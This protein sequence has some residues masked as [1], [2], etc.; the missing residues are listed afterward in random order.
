[1]VF[2]FCLTMSMVCVIGIR[3]SFFSSF[4]FFEIP[5]HRIFDAWCR[6]MFFSKMQLI[7]TRWRIC[8]FWVMYTYVY[9]N[10]L[11][12]LCSFRLSIASNYFKRKYMF[13]I[14]QIF[15]YRNTSASWSLSDTS[16]NTPCGFPFNCSACLSSRSL[17]NP[18]PL[19]NVFLSS[20]ATLIN[21]LRTFYFKSLS[22]ILVFGG[23]PEGVN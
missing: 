1:M 9:N 3:P 7:N 17:K 12:V 4:F 19:S 8:M 18:V 23:R 16:L 5:F 22:E 20:N 13:L 21:S 14:F 2:D 11:W 15:C 6:M 10:V